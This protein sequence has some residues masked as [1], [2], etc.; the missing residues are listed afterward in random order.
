M[1]CRDEKG[2]T[3]VLAI[4]TIFVILITIAATQTFQAGYQRS[5]RAIQQRQA[6]STTLATLRAIE[7]ELNNTI[8]S[9]IYAAVYE[10][11]RKG[12]NREG[13]EQRVRRYLN[14]RIDGGWSYSNF[15]SIFVPRCD[16][17]SLKLEWQ[18]DGS[19][20]AVGYLQASIE[21]LVGTKAHGIRV[22]VRATPRF[23]R[24]K[25]VANLAYESALLTQD[26]TRLES[27]LNE[28]YASEQLRFILE[29]GPKVTVMDLW[30]AKRVVV[31]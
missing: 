18:P 28:N 9:A 15:S 17:N 25:R 14:E 31:G 10:A 6:A 24:L 29:P 16:E 12:E 7:S 26:L 11:G 27:E 30:A 19:I 5:S 4:F 23:D 3:P 1:N 2:V 21:H 13:V 22:E 20:R 8:H